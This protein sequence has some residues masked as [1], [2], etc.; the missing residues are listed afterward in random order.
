MD[1]RNTRRLVADLFAKLE[2]IERVQR[3]QAELLARF[4]RR[5]LRSIGELPAKLLE[6]LELKIYELRIARWEAAKAGAPSGLPLLP[7]PAAGANRPPS[8][9]DAHPEPTRP[10]MLTHNDETYV[11]ASGLLEAARKLWPLLTLAAAAAAGAYSWMVAH[12]LVR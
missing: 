2:Q 5:V 4:E 9:S 3:D 10:F 7:P 6:F 8:F 12:G 1:D 11:K